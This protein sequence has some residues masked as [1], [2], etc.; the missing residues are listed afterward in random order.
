MKEDQMLESISEK[1]VAM[2]GLL[3]AVFT[4]T[5]L[6]ASLKAATVFFQFVSAMC[7]AIVGV[8]TLAYVLKKQFKGKR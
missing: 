7:A 8:I 4:S 2:R 6:V 1:A 5:G 3:G